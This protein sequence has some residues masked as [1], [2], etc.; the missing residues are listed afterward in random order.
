MTPDEAAR[1]LGVTL[2]ASDEQI[3]S[4][5]RRR[6]RQTHPDRHGSAAAFIDVATARDVLLRTQVAFEPVFVRAPTRASR[7]LILTWIGVALIAIFIAT[8]R[9]ELPFTWLEPFVR[10]TVLL[11]ALVGYA[12]TGKRLYLIV[13]SAA[14]AVTAIL[15]VAFATIGG[16][17]GLLILIAPI[18]GLAIM[19]VRAAARPV[20]SARR[21]R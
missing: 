14:I 21:E 12:L 10:Y 11:G 5:Y 1:V 13:A 4:A 8:V 18:Y 20:D 16:L 9:A 3:Q 2:G 15:T 17:V 19:G 7:P 6:A